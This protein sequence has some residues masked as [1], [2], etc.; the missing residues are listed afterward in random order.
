MENTGVW[1]PKPTTDITPTGPTPPPREKIDWGI[2]E[3]ADLISFSPMI[4]P[5]GTNWVYENSTHGFADGNSIPRRAAFIA[6]MRSSRRLLQ[7]ISIAQREKG[8]W[9]VSEATLETFSLLH[10]LK[11]V[12]VPHAILFD[13]I[14]VTKTGKELDE[15]LNKG[16]KHSKAGCKDSMIYFVAKECFPGP[17]PYSSYYWC[18]W[19]SDAKNVWLRYIKWECLPP[20]LLHPV[21]DE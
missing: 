1:G 19:A 7:L 16:P 18:P 10:G 21:K 15:M 5:V 6:V 12:T 3:D 20:M 13:D 17:W 4:D 14:S 8:Q 11:A 9:T 2:K